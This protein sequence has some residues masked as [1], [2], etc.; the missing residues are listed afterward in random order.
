M[1]RR[2]YPLCG[3][4][5]MS[6]APF[7][8][9]GCLAVNTV[10]GVGSLLAPGPLQFAGT[11][12]GIAN[13]T[14][15]YAV[16]DRTPLQVVEEDFRV[17]GQILSPRAFAA[18]GTLVS[19]QLTLAWQGQERVR[20][21]ALVRQPEPLRFQNPQKLPGWARARR[22]KRLMKH[23]QQGARV[24]ALHFRAGTRPAALK[25]TGRL[26]AQR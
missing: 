1:K 9:A 11:F 2:L 26:L 24:V 6:A 4:F 21:R 22:W 14:F 16:N 17:L 23:K 20:L 8:L 7:A 19:P 25:T 15:Q 5:F 10:L 3:L 12:Y 13:Y 18:R